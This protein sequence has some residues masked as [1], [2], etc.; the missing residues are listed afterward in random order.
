MRSAAPLARDAAT[1]DASD[2]ASD[3][4]QEQ[5]DDED[6]GEYRLSVNPERPRKISEKKRLDAA[7]FQSWIEK[8]QRQISSASNAKAK[9]RER[10]SVT[11]LIGD[12]PKSK[13]IASP[14]EYQIDLF[15]RAK[16]KNTIVVLDT[17]MSLVL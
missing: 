9:E 6:E 7:A 12:D 15:E 2:E 10:Q 5:N 13:I 8:N 1:R 4:G 11:D 3:D 17:G 14:R 16:Q